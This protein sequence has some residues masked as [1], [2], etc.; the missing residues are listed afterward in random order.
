MHHTSFAAHFHLLMLVASAMLKS[1]ER[2]CLRGTQWNQEQYTH[3]AADVA[4][5]CIG[6][7]HLGMLCNWALVQA[8][9]NDAYLI[10]SNTSKLCSS[11]NA[12]Q[13]T[14]RPHQNSMLFIHWD[15]PCT[16]CNHGGSGAATAALPTPVQYI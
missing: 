7:L 2:I 10:E 16:Q 14:N 4:N 5:G 6:L 3:H 8:G 13:A 1:Q 9:N 11:S 15:A 12:S